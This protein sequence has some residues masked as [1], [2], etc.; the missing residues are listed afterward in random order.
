MQT[1]D[2]QKNQGKRGK[3]SVY[4]APVVEKIQI[5]TEFTYFSTSNPNG[6]TPP[7]ESSIEFNPLKFFK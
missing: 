7:G 2:T 6:S 1:R 5:D 4:Q 3:R